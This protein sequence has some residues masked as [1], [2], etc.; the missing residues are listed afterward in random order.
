MKE[1]V[2][3][4]NEALAPGYHRLVF[5]GQ[6]GGMPGQFLMIK[7]WSTHDPLLARPFSLHEVEK[8]HFSIFFQVRGRGTALLA[9][10]KPG[11]RASVLGPL[12][13]GFPL[14]EKGPFILVAGGIGIAPFK[15]LVKALK[16]EEIFL[17]YGAKR[18]E[19]LLLLEEFQ[20][21]GVKVF[22]A[23]E[24]GSVGF[25]GLVTRPLEEF[26]AQNATGT[27]YACGP[28][29]MLKEVARLARAFNVKAYLSLEARMACGLGLCLGCVIKGK[30]GRFLHLCTEGPVVPAEKVF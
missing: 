17:F 24:D 3:C 12:G 20:K 4:Q 7:A 10:L 1:F 21:L 2:L 11:D 6:L 15:F 23:T 16:D 22:P 29:P 18:A 8:E 19:E 28:N 5:K 26:L 13:R 9:Q 25:H 27:I 30:G 14:N